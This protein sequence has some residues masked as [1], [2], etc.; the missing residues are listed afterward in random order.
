MLS[1]QAAFST[2][3][4]GVL[5]SITSWMAIK[6]SE[7]PV[8]SGV[9]TQTGFIEHVTLHQTNQLGQLAYSGSVDS[10]TQFSNGNNNFTNL[11]ATAYNQAGS[12]P[13]HLSAPQGQTLNNNNQ[14]ILSGNV[15]LTRDASTKIRPISIQ[16]QSVTIYPQQNY[17]ETSYPISITE[18]GTR[19]ITTAVGAEAYFK[20]Q[21]VT[22]LSQVNSTYEPKLHP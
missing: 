7:I 16:T 3:A 14:V 11:L 21:R 1:K 8:D 19:N 5:V 17:A 22:L 20:L 9:V 6:N 12:P 15:V 13:W 4:L 2:I 10:I 18:P